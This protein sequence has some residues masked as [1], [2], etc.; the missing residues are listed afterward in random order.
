[1]PVKDP[2]KKKRIQE[3]YRA[4]PES[5]EYMRNFHRLHVHG[6]TPETFQALWNSQ[7]GLCYLCEDPLEPGINTVIE[8]DHSCC[9]KGRS[10]DKCRRG[11]AHRKCNLL[12]GL[13]NDNP[14]LLMKIAMNFKEKNDALCE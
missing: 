13:A 5:K 10:C 14:D 6:L 11:L 9:I 1:M 12:L 2:A 3:R 4:K 8:H 7:D